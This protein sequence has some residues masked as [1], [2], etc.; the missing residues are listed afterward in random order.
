MSRKKRMREL[1]FN[2]VLAIS[3]ILGGLLSRIS[4]WVINDDEAVTRAIR[5][6]K[7]LRKAKIEDNDEP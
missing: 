1:S 2:E 5:I 4:V 6:Y 7:K 3:P